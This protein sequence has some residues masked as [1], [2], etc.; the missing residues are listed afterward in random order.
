[1]EERGGAHKGIEA[2]IHTLQQDEERLHNRVGGFGKFLRGGQNPE[3]RIGFRHGRN[4]GLVCRYLFGC[5]WGWIFFER[6][7]FN[8]SDEAIAASGQGFNESRVARRVPE[9]FADAIY[10]G[11]YAVVKIDKSPVGPQSL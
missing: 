10:R 7:A 2:Q 9:C 6:D 5:N 1:M 11:V 4:R 3:T 8:R